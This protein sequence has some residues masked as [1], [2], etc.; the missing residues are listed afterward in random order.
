MSMPSGSMS[1]GEHVPIPANTEPVSAAQIYQNGRKAVVM[2]HG[3]RPDGSYT[4]GTGFVHDLG[5]RVVITNAHVVDGVAGL[6]AV[7]FD[8]TEQPA[9]VVG[10][11]PCTDLAVVQIRGDLPKGSV[12]LPLGD[13]DTL[14]PGDEVTAVGFPV[15]QLTGARAVPKTDVV[16]DLLVSADINPALPEY[17]DAIQHGATLRAGDSGGPLLDD[18][19]NVVG[20][21]T[22]AGPPDRLGQYY[23][24]P[25]DAAHHETDE[26]MNGTNA[27][28]LGWTLTPHVVKRPRADVE[29][30]LR[31][32]GYGGGMF[33]E[34]TEPGGAVDGQ[35]KAGDLVA[36]LDD[37]PV[38]TQKEVCDVVTSVPPGRV[39]TADGI[40]VYSKPTL[41]RFHAQWRMPGTP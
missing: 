41:G 30:A 35:V 28:S 12:R 20:I 2:L 21:N 32:A 19:G 17:E 34:S 16:Q 27:N 26:L 18:K 5:N 10:S 39:M 40:H 1:M 29:S 22:M 9:Y 6:Q 37:A 31:Q 23:A 7:F 15:K 8:G 14:A 36:K 38:N 33:V 24:I 4:W 25:I 3:T 13:S 11:D